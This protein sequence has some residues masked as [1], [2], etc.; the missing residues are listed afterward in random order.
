MKIYANPPQPPQEPVPEPT[1]L[2]PREKLSNFWFYH[3]WKV[4]VALFALILTVVCVSQS[5]SAQ[6]DDIIIMYAGPVYISSEDQAAMSDAISTVLPDDFNGDGEKRAALAVLCIY[7]PEQITEKN[8]AAENGDG[9]KV[10]VSL[11]NSE[12]QSFD[13]LIVAG[14]YSLCLLDPWLYSEV[15]SAGGFRYLA[16]V[17]GEKP[18]YA[19]DDFCV[20]FKDTEFAKANA[21]IFASLPDDTLLCLRTKSSLGSLIAG[22]STDK[23]YA[24]AEKTFVAVMNYGS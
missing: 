3:K 1:V 16:D 13:Q 24:K 11:N 10:D 23:N 19:V 5:C 17:L 7:S 20:R 18:E 22:N 15:S 21:E 8:A 4:I 14:E 6:K 12:K 2:T 9:M